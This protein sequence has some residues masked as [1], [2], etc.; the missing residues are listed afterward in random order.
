MFQVDGK[1]GS[2]YRFVVLC[3][4]RSRQLMEG[5]QVRVET[6]SQKPAYI[7]MQEITQDKVD[8]S[9]RE[10]EVPALN[11]MGEILQVETGS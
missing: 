5:A 1:V 7:S 8:W 4:Q 11:E 6:A 2:K 10:T 9:I 3:A